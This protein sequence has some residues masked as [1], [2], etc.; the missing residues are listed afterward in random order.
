METQRSLTSQET[1]TVRR[2]DGFAHEPTVQADYLNHLVSRM[3]PGQ[4][5]DVSFRNDNE[6]MQ[7]GEAGQHSVTRRDP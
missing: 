6:C 3:K 2:S 1:Q 7:K 4:H 5:L